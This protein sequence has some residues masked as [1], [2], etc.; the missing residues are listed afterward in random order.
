MPV[1]SVTAATFAPFIEK[2]GIALIDLWASWCGPCR[3]FAPIFAAAAGR[4]PTVAFGKVDTEAE[5]ALAS[6]LGVRAIPTL[7]LFRD[8]IL[9]FSHA[10]VVSGSA[11]DELIGQAAALDMAE[12]RKQVLAAERAAG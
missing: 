7:L 2:E 12:V 5:G 4:H 11:L 3:T 6:A 1:T 9:L 8:G 10:G